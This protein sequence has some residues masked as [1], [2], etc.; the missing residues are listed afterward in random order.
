MKFICNDINGPSKWYYDDTD[1][2]YCR[3][4]PSGE[5]LVR[6]K[7][8]YLTNPEMIKGREPQPAIIKL[9]EHYSAINN[10]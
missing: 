1:K 3:R 4:T 10:R 7:G 5:E 9:W 6:L 2:M 8:E